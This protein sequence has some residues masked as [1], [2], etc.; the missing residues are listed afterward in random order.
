MSAIWLT[1]SKLAVEQDYQSAYEMALTQSDDIYLLR[2]IVQTGPVLTKGLTDGTAKKVL[3]RLNRIVR[4]GIFYKIQ[5]D[6]LDEA[7]KGEVFRNLNHQE[8]NEYLDT[9]FQFANPNS[10]LV[11]PELKDRAAEVYR[12]AKNQARN[13]Y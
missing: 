4:G 1:I 10:D 11:K 6:W 3:Q 5:I 8:Q 12:I 7:R 13:G 2:L 9:L